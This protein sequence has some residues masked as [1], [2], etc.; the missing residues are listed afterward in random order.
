MDRF[1]QN[2]VDFEEILETRRIWE[3]IK[4]YEIIFEVISKIL[5]KLKKIWGIWK[6]F[7]NFGM[8]IVLISRIFDL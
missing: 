4:F 7:E 1:Y 3:L 8:I 2:Y 5:E 6:N